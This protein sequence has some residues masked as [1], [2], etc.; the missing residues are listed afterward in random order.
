MSNQSSTG[1]IPIDK[2]SLEQASLKSLSSKELSSNRP[3]PDYLPLPDRLSSLH[4]WPNQESP[5]RSASEKYQSDMLDLCLWAKGVDKELKE[6]REKVASLREETL[7]LFADGETA[8]VWVLLLQHD[9]Q[10][11]IDQS[12]TPEGI[13]NSGL[14]RAT[15]RMI[16]KTAYR[17][18]EM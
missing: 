6:Q 12:N 9:P 17:K 16:L 8:R 3:S 14:D 11:L 2:A 1:G 5:G 18:L 13:A 4:S 10:A 7:A 15:T